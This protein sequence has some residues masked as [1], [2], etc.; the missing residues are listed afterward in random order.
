MA[1]LTV[2]PENFYSLKKKK[3]TFQIIKNF[4]CDFFLFPLF[5]CEALCVA[6]F[7]KLYD[8]CYTNKARVETCASERSEHYSSERRWASVAEP[9]FDLARWG[10]LCGG[11]EQSQKTKQ[12]QKPKQNQNR[13]DCLRISS[14]RIQNVLYISSCANYH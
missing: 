9:T 14:T 12:K 5:S 6:F 13:T 4:F 11:N 1:T 3:N 8:R 7:F 10:V 2:F